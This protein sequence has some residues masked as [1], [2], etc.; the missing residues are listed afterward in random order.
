MPIFE[1]LCTA[2]H[3]HEVIDLTRQSDTT[4][5]CP[6]CGGPAQRQASAAAFAFAETG[7]KESKVSQAIRRVKKA[8]REGRV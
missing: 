7:A 3:R 2:G 8:E 6:T 1:Y 4:R 5:P